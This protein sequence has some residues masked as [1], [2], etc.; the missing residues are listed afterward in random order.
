MKDSKIT[1]PKKAISGARGYELD[2]LFA[3]PSTKWDESSKK[4]DRKSDYKPPSG[5]G[6]EECKKLMNSWL[7]GK[8]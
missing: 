6:A 1:Q 8:I 7:K 3:K 5:E 4:N 2:N